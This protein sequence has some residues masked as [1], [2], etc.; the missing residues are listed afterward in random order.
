MRKRRALTGLATAAVIGTAA[1]LASAAPAQA[2]AAQCEQYIA[3]R[4]YSVGAKVKEA[5]RVADQADRPALCRDLLFRAGVTY[6]E[7]AVACALGIL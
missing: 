5:C 4:G 3:Q 7:A 6:N 2:N 1:A